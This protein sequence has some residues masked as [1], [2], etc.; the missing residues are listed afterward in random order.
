QTGAI[1]RLLEVPGFAAGELVAAD[2][3]DDDVGVLSNFDALGD[4]AAVFVGIAG[5]DFVLTPLAGLHDFAAF[6]VEHIHAVADF[7]FDSVQHRD[8]VLGRAAVAAVEAAAG[9]GADDGD[10]LN[11]R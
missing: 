6:A 8:V 4:L 11:L 1:P 3:E 10:R 7:R 5:E 9:V 2:A